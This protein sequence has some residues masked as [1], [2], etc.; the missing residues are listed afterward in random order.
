[1][2]ERLED[3]YWNLVSLCFLVV[4]AYEWY[5]LDKISSIHLARVLKEL[6]E[7]LPDKPPEKGP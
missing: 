1:M 6:S 2:D 5:L 4:N 3:D 7:A